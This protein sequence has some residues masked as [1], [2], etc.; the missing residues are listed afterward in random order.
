MPSKV[1]GAIRIL[2]DRCKTAETSISVLNGKQIH[3]ARVLLGWSVD[4][5]A[6]RASVHRT[7]LRRIE[8]NSNSIGGHARTVAKIEEILG[9]NGIEFIAQGNKIGVIINSRP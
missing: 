6:H 7:T 2:S 3:S 5:L 9:R 8:R 1:N 4:Q